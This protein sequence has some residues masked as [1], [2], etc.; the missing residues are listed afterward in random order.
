MFI[1]LGLLIATPG[2]LEMT[3]RVANYFQLGVYLYYVFHYF[4][5]L[6]ESY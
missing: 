5:Y 4:F 3:G 1:A 6:K 2:L